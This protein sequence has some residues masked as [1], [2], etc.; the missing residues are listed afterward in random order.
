MSFQRGREHQQ[1]EDPIYEECRN[2]IRSV[3]K[4]EEV[5][6][7]DL[8]KLLD[9]IGRDLARRIKMSQLRKVLD[10]FEKVRSL[11][12]VEEVNIK[13][14]AQPLKIHLAYAA[15]RQPDLRPLQRVLSEIIDK[16]VDA[17]DFKKLAQIMEGLIAYHKFY[18]GAD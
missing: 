9:G 12:R 1:R 8:I 6:S 3:R 2:L 16:V 13:E 5:K 7:E 15:G 17:K 18:G 14:E 4:L 10:A 11:T